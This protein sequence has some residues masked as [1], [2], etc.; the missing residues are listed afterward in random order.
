MSEDMA[1]ENSPSRQGRSMGYG[2][3]ALVRALEVLLTRADQHLRN[4]RDMTDQEWD[5]LN[6]L[7]DWWVGYLRGKARQNASSEPTR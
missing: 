6:D 4:E 3:E 2:H 7:H 1:T 5:L